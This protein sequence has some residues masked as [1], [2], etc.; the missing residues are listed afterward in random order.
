M[1]KVKDDVAARMYAA[2]MKGV[3]AYNYATNREALIERMYIRILSELAA[4]RFKWP[5]LPESI[6]PRHLEL[7]LLKNALSVFYFDDEY[8]KF[9]ALRGAPVGEMNMQDDPIKF[10]VYGNR[11]IN[12]TLSAMPIVVQG[13][14]AKGQFTPEF[15]SVLPE[16]CVPIWAN[17]LRIPDWDIITVYANRLAQMDRTIEINSKNARRTKVVGVDP[18]GN[19][20][21]ENIVRQIDE[22]QPVIRVNN[23]S[24]DQITSQLTALD[25]GV[26]PDTIE[27]LQ[28]SR[29]RTWNEC[30]G[31]LGINNANQDKKERLVS[32]EV[33]ANNDQVET[34]RSVNLNARRQACHMIKTR[35]PEL[36]DLSVD[37]H[38]TAA[39]MPEP[40]TTDNMNDEE[41]DTSDD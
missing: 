24:F 22:G 37:F 33:D 3:Y 41:V 1:R 36:S 17:Y 28:I 31:L 8:N 32:D 12:K 6:N 35:W 13:R 23:S 11:F 27:K 15:T 30:M 19:L 5:G 38:Q 34:M 9:F 40:M 7:T 16:E 21:I 4:N 26:N 20:S 18:N 10:L 25:L 2:H 29:T 39:S 14:N